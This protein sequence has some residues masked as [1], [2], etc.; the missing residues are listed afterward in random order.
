MQHRKDYVHVDGAI[1][2]ATR[3]RVALKWRE[4]WVGTMHRLGWNYHSFASRQHGCTGRGIGI[5][6]AQMLLFVLLA[7]K[8]TL[9]VTGSDP[10]PLLGDADR[11]DFK[12]VL[13]DRIDDRG[14]GEQGHLM[15]TTTSTKENTHTQFVHETLSVG[16]GQARRQ[17]AAVIPKV[18]VDNSAA[19]RKS[20]PRGTFWGQEVIDSIRP[21]EGKAPA[22]LATFVDLTA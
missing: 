17:T 2:R 22:T 3:G 15:L 10:S 13:V 18:P 7:R 12:F 9:G 8:E 6:R 1:A 11:Y 20:V 4:R 21:A 5:A 14:C 19:K 16:R